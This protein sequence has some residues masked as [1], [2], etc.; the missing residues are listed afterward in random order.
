[1]TP[2]SEH[3]YLLFGELSGIGA[4]ALGALGM[5]AEGFKLAWG[6]V[7]DHAHVMGA[8]TAEGVNSYLGMAGAMILTAVGIAI[9]VW[10]SIQK[11]RL[12][13]QTLADITAANRKAIRAGHE[14]PFPAYLPKAPK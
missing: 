3:K 1:M 7:P 14:P 5:I 12:D 13:G 10:H 4:A 9:A 2:M 6:A 8:I 11:A